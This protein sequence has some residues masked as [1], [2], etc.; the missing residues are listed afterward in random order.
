MANADQEQK[1]SLTD[2]L[3]VNPAVVADTWT[4]D[5]EG[6]FSLVEIKGSSINA[7][8]EFPA[9]KQNLLGV[10]VCPASPDKCSQGVLPGHFKF[11]PSCQT[12]L[13]EPSALIGGAQSWLSPVSMASPVI[14]SALSG[15]TCSEQSLQVVS[16]DEV[17][18]QPDTEMSKPQTGKCH[19]FVGSFGYQET[20]LLAVDISAQFFFYF[21][22][23]ANAWE[24]MKDEDSYILE[25]PL[26]AEA[27]GCVVTDPLASDCIY[28]CCEN[29]LVEVRVDLFQR[30]LRSRLIVEGKPK[31]APAV[32]G[33]ALY[34]PIEHDGTQ[35]IYRHDLK[36]PEAEGE[37]FELPEGGGQLFHCAVQ[38]E[39]KIIWPGKNG[40]I[41]LSF[42]GSG[43]SCT[44]RP[45]PDNVEPEFEFGVPAR[46]QNQFWQLCFDHHNE[47]YCYLRLGGTSDVQEMRE[48]LNPRMT[49]GLT[50]FLDYENFKAGEPWFIQEQH[51][52]NGDVLLPL[53]EF[54]ANLMEV[55]ASTPSVLGIKLQTP[56]SLKE[57]LSSK[58]PMPCEVVMM[59]EPEQSLGRFSAEQPWNSECFVYN[60]HLWLY[61]PKVQQISG[62]ELQQ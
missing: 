53:M 17:R 24:R 19:F 13:Q 37:W 47:N 26:T 32:R 59:G 9:D 52:D 4:S 5:Q 12:S 49:S 2:N 31:A 42:I 1:E 14:N 54:S 38:D 27:W 22:P 33:D 15:L 21:N 20:R 10:K 50:H 43:I 41:I 40:Q 29:G 51:S 30:T 55:S 11:C 57:L 34:L 39:R 45:W 61:H 44:V 7:G 16:K 18:F 48:T 36:V 28:I 3:W 23:E 58:T 6:K 46:Y 60:N 56:E 62:W 35:K 25:S 8:S